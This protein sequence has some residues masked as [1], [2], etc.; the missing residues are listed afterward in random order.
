ML[1]CPWC[2]S[3]LSSSS[4][5]SFRLCTRSRRKVWVRAEPA[6]DGAVL[7]VGGFALQRKPQFEDEFAR[8]LEAHRPQTRAARRQTRRRANGQ[9]EPRSN[10][11][12]ADAMT[13]LQWARISNDAFNVALFAYLAAMVGYFAYLA[14]RREWL[15]KVSRAVAVRGPWP[16]T[17]SRSWPGGSPP[18]GC[19]GATCTSTRRCSRCWWSAGSS[20]IV[21]GVYKIRTLGGFAL[22]FRC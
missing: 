13:D 15:W 2:C 20:F 16:P 18:T 14:F 11:E 3:R 7:K 21:E 10:E 4:W 19:R 5:G 1:G 6:G 8:L 12:G 17:S 9:P 22:M